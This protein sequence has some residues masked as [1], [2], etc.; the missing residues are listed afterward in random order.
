M[1]QGELLVPLE[2][3]LLLAGVT[4]SAS[5]LLLPASQT[6]WIKTMMLEV[7]L[8]LKYF[9]KHSRADMAMELEE[10]FAWVW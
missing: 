1:D 4:Y 8:L 7:M 6:F 2:Y 5:P 10:L 3:Q 9:T